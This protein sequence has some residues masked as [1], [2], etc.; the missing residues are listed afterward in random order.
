MF[1]KTAD[2]LAKAQQHSKQVGHKRKS[3]LVCGLHRLGQM[4]IRDGF[5]SPPSLVY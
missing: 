2:A 5:S 3:A 4:L 1:C